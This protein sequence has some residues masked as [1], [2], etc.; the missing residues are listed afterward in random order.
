MLSEILGREY[1][2]AALNALK[3]KGIVASRE[4]TVRR[5]PYR[6]LESESVAHI[7]TEEQQNAVFR[8]ES[9]SGVY[10]LHGVTGS[11]KTEVYMRVIEDAVKNNKTAVMLVPEISL[12]PNVM[13]LF[14]NRF[15]DKVAL[16]HSGLSAGERFDEWHRLKTG[17]AMIAVGAR[18][19]IFAPLKNIGVIIIDEEHDGSY[20]SESN[21]RYD[22][23]EVAEFRRAYNDC[24]LVLGERY[25]VA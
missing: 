8:I 7:L 11:G 25:A 14:R 21:P 17:E 2:A 4:V 5:T 1:G 9:A 12:T 15:K 16:L 20:F 19:A 24:A 23:Q 18:S 6:G 10:L 13:R 22:T 3:K